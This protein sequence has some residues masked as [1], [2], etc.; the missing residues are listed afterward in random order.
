MSYSRSSKVLQQEGSQLLSLFKNAVSYTLA[1]TALTEL[2]KSTPDYLFLILG[3]LSCMI[4][5][6][7]VQTEVNII[8]KS[9]KVT[10]ALGSFYDFILGPLKCTS[11]LLSIVINILTQFLSTLLAKYVLTFTPNLANFEEIIYI[12]LVI[13]SLF[14]CVIY[15]LG[16]DWHQL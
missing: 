9:S 6:L 7:F 3:T 4:L 5:L 2:S 11:F 8:L 12:L 13:L 10:K 15:A 14:W 1:I 16:V